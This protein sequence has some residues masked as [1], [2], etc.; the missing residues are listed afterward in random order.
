MVTIAAALCTFLTRPE[1]PNPEFP[2]EGSHF[3]SHDEPF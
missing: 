3:P 2:L 1:P